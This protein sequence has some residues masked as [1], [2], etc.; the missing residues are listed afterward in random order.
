MI[1][2]FNYNIHIFFRKSWLA[3]TRNKISSTVV[4]LFNLVPRD[5]QS[6]SSV[7]ADLAWLK[8]CCDSMLQKILRSIK[9]L[10]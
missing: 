4:I 7:T 8:S 10:L 2:E 1:N 5:N 9:N 3:S 6:P